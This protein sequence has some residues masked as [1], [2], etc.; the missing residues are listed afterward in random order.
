MPCRKLRFFMIHKRLSVMYERLGL[1]IGRHPLYF[2]FIPLLFAALTTLGLLRL[3]IVTDAEYLYLPIHGESSKIRKAIER[4]LPQNEFDFDLS[5]II[6]MKGSCVIIAT[7]KNDEFMLNDAIFDELQ[8]LDRNIW[9]LNI[10]WNQRNLTYNDICRK[11]RESCNFNGILTLRD[12]I[13]DIKNKKY[14]IRYPLT[15]GSSSINT[16]A[17]QLGGVLTDKDNFVENFKAI[18]LTYFVDNSDSTRQQISERWEEKIINYVSRVSFVHVQLSKMCSVSANIESRII[19]HITFYVL[20]TGVILIILASLSCLSMDCVRSKPLIG[21]SACISSTLGVISAFGIL[22]LC[23]M[24]FVELTIMVLFIVLGIGLDD[25]FVLVAAWRKTDPKDSVEK[26]ISEAY[27][28]AAVSI[29]ITS[30]TNTICAVIGISIPVKVIQITSIYLALSL[31]MDYVYQMTFFGGCL[32][33]SGYREAKNLHAFLCMPVTS[34][35]GFQGCLTTNSFSNDGKDDKTET[36][37]YRDKL[38]KLLTFPAVKCFVML[39][40]LIYLSGGI[41]FLKYAHLSTDFSLA[42]PKTSYIHDFFRY[43][44]KYFSKFRDRIHILIDKPL[45]Y[46]DMNIQKRIEKLT[47]QLENSPHMAG[48]NYTESWLRM[49]LNFIQNPYS[50]ISLRG[51]NM[52]NPDDFVTVLRNIFLKIKWAQSLNNDIKFSPDGKKILGSRFLVLT[53]LVDNTDKEK[54]VFYN[55]I[56]LTKQSD[57]PARPFNHRFTYFDLLFI[58]PA[59]LKQSIIASSCLVILVFV[60]AI[61][62]FVCAI[63]IGFTIASIEVI[64]IGYMSA[65]GISINGVSE[66]ILIFLAGF[67]TDYSTHISYAYASSK[68]T[69]SNEKIKDSLHSAGSAIVKGCISTISPFLVFIDSPYPVFNDLLKIFSLIMFSALFLGLFIIPV[70]LSFLDNLYSL[71]RKTK[72]KETNQPSELREY[73]NVSSRLFE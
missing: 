30:L 15:I 65:W 1:F 35:S 37:F 57:I 12:K 21:I 69:G 45:D 19:R 23:G 50:W 58:F 27:S 66:I 62:N 47:N 54:E 7:A 28:E 59:I 25:S 26:R 20:I 5:R 14:R 10:Y 6:D 48:Q 67:C 44:V 4:L 73:P 52:S 46:S 55:M 56:Q 24:E 34:K 39:L 42:F 9:N 53:D 36:Y 61:P 22:L 29:T 16:D 40:F 41:Y 32:A 13:E 60:I 70:M 11:Y 8:R 3:H 71:W 72:N 18:R 63:C 33:I 49:Y 2:V 31:A 68:Q 38:G 43:D 64:T 17:I 51:Y